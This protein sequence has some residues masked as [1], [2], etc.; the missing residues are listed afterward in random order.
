M[1][2]SRI[3]HFLIAPPLFMLLALSVIPLLLTVGLSLTSVDIA[4]QGGWVGFSNYERLLADPIFIRSYLNTLIYVAIGLPIQYALGLGLALLVHGSPGS[5]RL[6][7]LIIP[8]PLMVAPL[9]VGF[10]WK[11]LL[12]SRFGPMNDLLSAL[13]IAP[14]PWIIDSRL[15]FI[16][17]LIVDTWQWTPFIFLILYAGLRTLPI[18]P[19][20][21]A[22]VDG[23]SRW[24]IFW[25]ITFPMLLPASVAAIM[26]RAIEA[27]KLFDIV[28]YITGGGPGSATST[29]TL[30]AYFTGLRSGYVGY[31]GAMAVILFITVA[32]FGTALP[33]AIRFATRRRN[34]TLKMALMERGLAR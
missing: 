21:A 18:E 3:K 6:W 32:V 15:A 13:G 33:L 16:S 5:Q 29:V 26:L 10:I 25:D 11:T 12:D 28:F 9:V 34:T 20:E 22:R 27:F 2:S 24:R 31:G 14:I 7:R 23:A 1:E 4:G 17:I 8:V 19:F 30:D